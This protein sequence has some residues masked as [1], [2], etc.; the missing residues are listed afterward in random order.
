LSL[1]QPT[2]GTGLDEHAPELVFLRCGR[3]GCSLAGRTVHRSMAH[4]FSLL[5]VALDR[6]PIVLVGTP[7]TLYYR[8]V[9]NQGP[10]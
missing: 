6:L 2:P 4:C 8:L 3:Q 7:T 1:R 9:S 5:F 10:S